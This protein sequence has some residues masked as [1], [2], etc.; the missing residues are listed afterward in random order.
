[1]LQT[2]EMEKSK[3]E[4]IEELMAKL[5]EDL[6]KGRIKFGNTLVEKMDKEECLVKEEEKAEMKD[7]HGLNFCKRRSGY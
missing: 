3:E 4:L 2:E 7:R 6:V 5:K 1:M